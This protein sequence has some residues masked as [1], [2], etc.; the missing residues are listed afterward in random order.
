MTIKVNCQAST[1]TILFGDVLGA[2]SGRV[3]AQ[4]VA[5]YGVGYMLFATIALG[6][7]WAG[8]WALAGDMTAS[9]FADR[10]L[11]QGARIT[12]E[13]LQL[14][15]KSHRLKN[16]GIEYETTVTYSFTMPDGRHFTGATRRVLA[17]PPG[18][19]RGGPIDVLYEPGNPAH[20]TMGKEFAQ[21]MA[22]KQYT[23]WMLLL[24]SIYPALFVYRYM[25][26]RREARGDIAAPR[27]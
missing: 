15:V 8:M 7:M 23:A 25:K 27:P 24:L 13:V 18:L 10:S 4:L 19:Q 17:S 2:F 6:V 12:G 20:N 5:R 9:Y 1:A 26:W 3:Y 21:D 22:L 16:S 14:D 11:L